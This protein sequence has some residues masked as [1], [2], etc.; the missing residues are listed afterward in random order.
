MIPVFIFVINFWNETECYWNR[1]WRFRKNVKMCFIWCRLTSDF[2]F[3]CKD[4]RVTAA[5]YKYYCPLV[6]N[7]IITNSWKKLHLLNVAEFLGP[8][9][10]T[11]PSM[12]TSS[13]SCGNQ[14]FFFLFR[15]VATFIESCFVF[16]CYF[17][18]VW[19]SFF[20]QPFRRLL[21]LSCSYGSLCV[22]HI[23]H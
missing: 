10:Q 4:G 9:L 17:F 3:A 21:P 1:N 19:W 12:K 18:T 8:S 14:S 7:P 16:L 2:N 20:D 5:T 15:N 22:D 13:V 6:V 11:S 23:L